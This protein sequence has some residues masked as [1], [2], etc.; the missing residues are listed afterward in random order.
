M[1]QISTKSSGSGPGSAGVIIT[2]FTAD[3]SWTKN[4][5]TKWVQYY[6]W[7][8]GGGG[9]SGAKGINNAA[10]GG[11]G[12]VSNFLV[13][14]ADASFF[15]SPEAITVGAG[16][17]GGASRTVDTGVGNPGTDGGDSSIGTKI[18]VTGVGTAGLGG[19]ITAVAVTPATGSSCGLGGFISIVGSAAALPSGAPTNPTPLF[20][21]GSASGG[22]AGGN[23]TTAFTANVSQGRAG[24]AISLGTSVILA[25]GTAGTIA[26]ANG[27]NG[28]DGSSVSPAAYITGGTG[29]GGGACSGAVAGA[30]SGGNGGNGGTRGGGGGGGGG[31]LNSGGT[32]VGSGA[33]GNGGRGEVIIIEYL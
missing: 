20:L 3:G 22:G 26:A 2:S 8:G 24:A 6:I 9:G 29:G 25:G 16:G 10:G 4:A 15:A 11:G 12:G 7:S 14:C 31:C 27:N 13:G 28:A 18:V 17:T 5:D 23:Y 21:C 30:T 19:R 33:G 32:T 1:S